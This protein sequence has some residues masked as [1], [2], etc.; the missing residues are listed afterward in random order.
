MALHDIIVIGGSTG[1]LDV[2]K[3]LCA[4]LPANLPASVFVVVHI[5]KQGRNL[6]AEILDNLSPL[7]VTTAEADEPIEPGRI[8]VAPTDHHLLIQDGVVRLGRGPREN[9]TRPAIDPLFR[10]AAVAYGPRVIGV[11]LSGMLNDGSAGLA[12]VKQCGGLAVVQNPADAEAGDMPTHALAI[13]DVDYRA[14]A[15][16]LGELLGHLAGEPAG[17]AMR[18]APAMQWE[19]DIALGQSSTSPQLR[20]AADPTTISCPDCGG[21]LSEMHDRSPLRFRC[22]VGHAYTAEILDLEMDG[23][24]QEALGVALRILESRATLVEQMAADARARNRTHSAADLTERA[25]EYRRQAEIL[26]RAIIQGLK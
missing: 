14:P 5:G 7:R 26:N 10:S 18:V 9:M 15:A 17:P 3:R 6:L 2:L 11:V 20:K 4:D 22:Q 12:A 19:V 13:C 1:A 25:Q 21:V 16:R 24:A 8:Y 23:P